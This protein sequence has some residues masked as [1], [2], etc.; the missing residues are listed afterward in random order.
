MKTEVILILILTLIN[1]SC[2]E[3]CGTQTGVTKKEDCTK[4][5]LSSIEK[6]AGV[7]CCYETYTDDGQEAKNCVALIKSQVNDYKQT[8]ETDFGYTNVKVE[9]NSKWLNFSILLIG[10]FALLF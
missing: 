7:R 9:C 5:S 3:T 6:K 1:L 10:L 8:L 2:G 4:V